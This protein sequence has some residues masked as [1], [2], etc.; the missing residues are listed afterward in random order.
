MDGTVGHRALDQDPVC[1]EG[2]M[3]THTAPSSV[4]LGAEL[5]SKHQHLLGSLH[6]SVFTYAGLKAQHSRGLDSQRHISVCYRTPQL[7]Q[8]VLFLFP[9]VSFL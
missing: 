7:A 6:S 9:G 5:T 1:Q 2:I 4:S 8:I 3:Y